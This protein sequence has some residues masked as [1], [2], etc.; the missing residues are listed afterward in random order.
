MRL[1]WCSARQCAQQWCGGFEV[2][3]QA[4]VGMPGW[5][6]VVR[7]VVGGGWC[8]CRGGREIGGGGGGERRWGV[9]ASGG[10]QQETEAAG[11]GRRLAAGG[12]D[13]RGR[14]G[15]GRWTGQEQASQQAKRCAKE[16]GSERASR[17]QG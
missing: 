7:W 3:P 5:C 10:S 16:K 9:L 11:F 1:W 17:G 14:A 2:F 4:W 12:S 13:G 6:M 15:Q 8:W